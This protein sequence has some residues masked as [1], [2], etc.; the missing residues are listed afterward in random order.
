MTP[1][2]KFYVSVT[3]EGFSANRWN[4]PYTQKFF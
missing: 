1:H 2:A 4:R 3:K